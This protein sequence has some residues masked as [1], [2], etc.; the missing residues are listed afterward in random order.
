M[1]TLDQRSRAKLGMSSLFLKF[2]GCVVR[3]AC[4]ARVQG[5][6]W[7]N[8]YEGQVVANFK[9]TEIYRYV[10]VGVSIYS[11][12]SQVNKVMGSSVFYFLCSRRKGGIFCRW[13]IQLMVLKIGV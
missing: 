5:K 3:K 10:G 1:R 2:V 12:N 11:L 13:R 6:A 4:L 8:N 9:E 7:W